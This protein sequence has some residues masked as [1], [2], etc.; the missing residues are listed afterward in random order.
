MITTAHGSERARVLMDSVWTSLLGTCANTCSIQEIGAVIQ[1]QINQRQWLSGW[2]LHS[3]S[4]RLTMSFMIRERKC[5][6]STEPRIIFVLP[7][8]RGRECRL[9][10]H[11]THRSPRALG[12]RNL[13]HPMHHYSLRA[14]HLSAHSQ[15]E[16]TSLEVGTHLVAILR[17]HCQV[18]YKYILP[19]T[20][21]LRS[22]MPRFI[23]SF[24]L[25][26]LA[27]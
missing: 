7:L 4:F 12:P 21:Y 18:Q 3:N 25:R 11:L 1:F 26:F 17:L 5:V 27:W 22:I 2:V 19:I 13:I 15:N 10:D 8:S 23:R 24:F 14:I 16:R 6:T 20:L 9:A